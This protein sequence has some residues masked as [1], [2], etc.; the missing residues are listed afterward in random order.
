MIDAGGNCILKIVAAVD[1]SCPQAGS[2]VENAL[3]V[4]ARIHGEIT[5]ISVINR[6]H[7]ERGVRHPWPSNAFGKAFP[8]IDIHRVVLP[9]PPAQ[10]ISAYADQIRADLLIIPAQYHVR[11]WMRKL[12]LASL[13]APLTS[14]CVWTAKRG[15]RVLMVRF[16]LHV[17]CD[18]MMRTSGCVRLLKRFCKGGTENCFWLFM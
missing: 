16:V 4:A 17:C 11:R 13:A 18:L 6:H 3:T 14:R 12:P 2:T 1:L 7:F 10:A 8:D 15:Y 5:L 9:G